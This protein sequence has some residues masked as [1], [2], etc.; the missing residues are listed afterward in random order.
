[1]PRVF[2]DRREAGRVLAGLLSAYRGRTD[3][4]ALGLARGGVPVAWE[5]AAGLGVGLDV[6]LVR[7]LGVPQWPELAMGAVASGGAVVMNESV[8]R[9]VGVTAAQVRATLDRETVELVRR[10]TVYRGGRAAID[11]RARTVLLIDDGVATGAS[12]RVALRAVRAAGA[13]RLVAAVPV[14]PPDVGELLGAD[15]DDVECALIPKRFEAVGQAFADFRQVEDDEV[16][17][18]L[19]TPT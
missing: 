6:F 14:G 1:M 3:V 19:R 17:T 18:L 5:V 8:V 2:R 15:A 11:V 12:M 9:S 16:R 4:V 7:K 13:Q 10:E